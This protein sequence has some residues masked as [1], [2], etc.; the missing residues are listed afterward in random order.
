MMRR[1]VAIA[2]VAMM[3]CLI[4]PGSS[5]ASSV[6]EIVLND[7]SVINGEI[8]SYLNGVY[9]IKSSTLGTITINDSIVHSISA[10]GASGSLG[11]SNTPNTNTSGGDKELSSPMK[12]LQQKMMSDK[13]IMNII[14]SLKDDHEFQKILED[15]EIMKAINNNDIQ[16]LMKNQKIIS[17][18][19]HPK[20]KEIEKRMGQ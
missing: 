3:V 1:L 4:I 12:E 2:F 20:V 8:I 17:L 19:N 15:P 7:G 5:T 6:K 10:K 13:E 9:T 16:A 11:S 18:L 14:L